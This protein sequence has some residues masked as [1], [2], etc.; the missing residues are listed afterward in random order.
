MWV[1]SSATMKR[2][3][4]WRRATAPPAPSAVARR[5][6][7][8]P[9]LIVGT[10]N[11]NV[12]HVYWQTQESELPGIGTNGEGESI[13]LAGYSSSQLTNMRNFAQGSS[14]GLWD[15]SPQTNSGG[16]IWGVNVYNSSGIVNNGLPVLQWQTP[17]AVEVA[18]ASNTVTY[19]SSP[20]YVATGNGTSSLTTE[21]NSPNGPTITISNPDD[22]NAGSTH[23]V[24]FS[25]NPLFGG[26]NVEYVNGTLTYSGGQQVGV[27]PGYTVVPAPLTITAN[28]VSIASGQTVPTFTATYNGFVLGQG[29][30]NFNGTLGFTR[31]P[32]AR[33]RGRQLC[34]QSRRPKL[35]QLRHHVCSRHALDRRHADRWAG[36]TSRPPPR[37]RS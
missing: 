26:Y 28:N 23:Q 13:D 11:G 27:T 20:Q 37:R 33:R 18:L 6:G 15:F 3:A 8:Q 24:T 2:A 35:E 21:V 9:A 32:D 4:F 1:D 10:N 19:G 25:G 30:S 31:Q 36:K 34:D 5:F 22:I 17:V 7:V 12:Q 16:G 29:P 14:P